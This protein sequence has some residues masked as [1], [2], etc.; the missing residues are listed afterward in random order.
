MSSPASYR[1]ERRADHARLPPQR[2][3]ERG[4]ARL[5]AGE[6][7]LIIVNSCA[8]TNEGATDPPGDP[9]GQA[10]RPGARVIVPLR[11]AGRAGVIRGDARGEPGAWEQ[12]QKRAGK[13][14]RPFGRAC[15]SPPLPLG[16]AG[17]KDGPP[18]GSGRTGFGV[19]VSAPDIR[20]FSDIMQVRETAPH[21]AAGFASARGVRRGAKWLRPSLH[22]LHHPL[23]RGQQPLGAAGLV[24][25]RI[26][27]LVARAFAKW[28]CRVD[29]T[30]YGPDLPGAPTLGAFD[31][32]GSALRA[33]CCRAQALLARLHRDGR[34]LFDLATSEP[35]FMRSPHELPGRDD[36]ILK[37][38]KRRAFPARRG[39]DGSR[40]SSAKRPRS[41][42]GGSDRRLPPRATKW[43]EYA[44]PRRRVRIVMGHIFPFS[45]KRGT[46]AARMPQIPLPIAKERARR[47][48]DACAGRK[49]A[50][51][52]GLVGTRQKVLVEKGDRG[53]AENFA[54]VRIRH[55]R[56]SGNPASRFRGGDLVEVAV[57]GV[58]SGT[59]IGS[60]L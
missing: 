14:P 29:V 21:L 35:R 39:R 57:L 38:M 47:L 43:R 1:H 16:R 11:G 18:T 58:D 23:C 53:H 12:G 19:R 24:V 15:R 60:P 45:P 20:F 13:L 22:L 33:G 27:A 3:R 17:R 40:G 28:C 4:H 25:E 32:A 30:S 56:E 51:L 54:P 41:D 34:R 2:R 10:A 6:E 5:A 42:R 52:E 44:P 48:R 31:R 37:R 55:S 50:W 36:M 8:V 9:Q 26:A 59:L 7:D 49:E 46:P